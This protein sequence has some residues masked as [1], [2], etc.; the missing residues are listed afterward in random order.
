METGQ[1]DKLFA[2]ALTGRKQKSSLAA[3]HSPAGA[4]RERQ[5]S[6]SRQ[7]AGLFGVRTIC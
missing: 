4:V 6:F 2:V 5:A 7:D 3:L 1:A